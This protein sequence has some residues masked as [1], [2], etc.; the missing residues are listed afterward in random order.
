MNGPQDIGGRHGFGPVHPEDERILFHAEWEK[1]V[2]GITLASA[3]LGYWNIDASRHARESLAPAIYY[4]ASYYEIWLRSLENLLEEAGEISRDELSTGHAQTPG[5]RADRRMPAASVADIL[6]KGGPAERP[7]PAPVFAIGDRV[8]TRNHQ[9]AGHTRLPGYARG[10]CG[11]ITA[12]HG[13]HVFPDS[14]AHFAGEHPCP[15]Y[16][17]RFD[18]VDLFGADA[19]PTLTVTIEAWEPYLEHA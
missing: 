13:C 17:I 18:A 12:S 3:A 7:G 9:P 1:R 11:T 8:R 5:Q 2:L 16:T 6:A 14:N 4:N 15:L 19:D 10:Q